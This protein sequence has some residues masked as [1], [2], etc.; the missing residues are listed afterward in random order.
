MAFEIKA[1]IIEI[2]TGRSMPMS[3]LKKRF[4]MTELKQN[5]GYFK[6][7]FQAWNDMV[8][9]GHGL[10]YQNVLLPVAAIIRD[11]QKLVS[12]TL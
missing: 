8:T 12:D 7:G 11:Q 5:S 4:C 2:H 9:A 6:I 10:N 1:D 3:D